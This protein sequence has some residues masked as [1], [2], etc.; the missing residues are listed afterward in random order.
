LCVAAASVYRVTP[1]G[2]SVFAA[3]LLPGV[4]EDA[5]RLNQPSNAARLEALQALLRSRHVNFELQPFANDRQARDSRE[6]GQNVIVTAGS[7]RR[8]LIVGAH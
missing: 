1:G 4:I 7:G 3:E 8:D 2:R 5:S 6:Q